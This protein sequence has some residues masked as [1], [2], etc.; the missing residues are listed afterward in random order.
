[1]RF[2]ARASAG[3]NVL[4]GPQGRRPG[5]GGGDDIKSP[6]SKRAFSAD[7]TGFRGA[8]GARKA[9]GGGG[10]GGGLVG[11]LSRDVPL[12]YVRRGS[13]AMDRQILK[14]PFLRAGQQQQLREPAGFGVGESVVVQSAKDVTEWRRAKVV[15]IVKQNQ[16]GVMKETY[17]VVY[18]GAPGSKHSR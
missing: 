13:L 5:E 6:D 4:L 18:L 16:Q 15:A 2:V 3:S 1:M 10:G 12:E 7:R 11:M 17:S 8:S 14:N 9:P